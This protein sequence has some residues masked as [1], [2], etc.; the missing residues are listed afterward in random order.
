[1]R[2]VSRLEEIIL[3]S[4]WRLR[5]NA[6]GITILDEVAGSTGKM[7]LTGSIYASLARLLKQALVES[8]E[9]DPIP[10]RG[11]RKK[12]FYKLTPKGHKAL[13]EVKKVNSTIW[14]GLPFP[15]TEDE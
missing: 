8:Y 10:E 15:E 7:W 4:I 13:L 12:I 11:G 3:L 9:G 1:M 14:R 5:D 2:L 6:Y